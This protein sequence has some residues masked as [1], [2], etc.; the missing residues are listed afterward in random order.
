MFGFR[1]SNNYGEIV[2]SD[3]SY[4]LEYAG[5][6]TYS[7]MFRPTTFRYK[8]IGGGADLLNGPIFTGAEF[9]VDLPHDEFLAF[10]Y[11][12]WPNF[13]SV[14]YQ[15]PVTS[16]RTRLLVATQVSFVPTIYCF[17]KIQPKSGG[18]GIAV[19][20]SSGNL[21]FTTQ[22]KILVPLAAANFTVP[23]AGNIYT[24]FIGSEIIV[25]EGPSNGPEVVTDLGSLRPL[26]AMQ[27]PA[28]AYSSTSTLI[29]NVDGGFHEFWESGLRLNL[30]AGRF[31]HQ[32]G[33][34]DQATIVQRT[35]IKPGAHP[36]FAL[37]IDG[38]MYD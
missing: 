17:R 11:S 33:Y 28:I 29:V 37:A 21:T 31:E 25:L 6:A 16:T 4:T 10:S 3:S 20:D 30:S 35:N 34:I 13:T 26:P 8:A 22:S 38:A 23:S 14:M 2:V 32:Y 27:K 19:R 36:G 7:Q 5:K 1:V 15:I 9:F 18:H 24:R 12:Q